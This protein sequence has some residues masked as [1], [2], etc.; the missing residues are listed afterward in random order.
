MTRAHVC[1][2]FAQSGYSVAKR[3]LIERKARGEFFVQLEQLRKE[4]RRAQAQKIAGSDSGE[5][6]FA[7]P[8]SPAPLLG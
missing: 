6:E 8:F 2:M 4:Q 3:V 5:R 7:A 1:A